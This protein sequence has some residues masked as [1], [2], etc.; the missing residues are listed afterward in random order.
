MQILI[1]HEQKAKQKKT[2]TLKHRLATK[3]KS[4]NFDNTLICFKE[5]NIKLIILFIY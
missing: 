3:T 2:H 1:L 4:I 5:K